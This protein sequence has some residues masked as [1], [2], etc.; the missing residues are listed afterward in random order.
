M[1]IITTPDK[2][3][4][5]T[6]G[7][8]HKCRRYHHWHHNLGWAR[9]GYQGPLVH[10][11]AFHAGLARWYESHSLDEAINDLRAAWPHSE[12]V[13][14]DQIP[15]DQ[16]PIEID[17]YAL[18]RC[19]ALFKGY[20]AYWNGGQGAAQDPLSAYAPSGQQPLLEHIIECPITT[21]A[22]R[23]LPGEPWSTSPW[24]YFGIVDMIAE[25][26]GQ[27]YIVDHKTCSEMGES[28]SRKWK[29][30]IQMLGYVV[31]AETMLGLDRPI[32]GAIINGAKMT[33]FVGG[34]KGMVFPPEKAANIE[35]RR[36]PIFYT[37]AEKAQWVRDRIEERRELEWHYETGVW[38]A[39]G[40]D[41][42][43]AY[44]GCQF[45]DVCGSS[46]GDWAT[47]LASDFK[48]GQHWNPLG[49]ERI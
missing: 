40:R 28:F 14:G 37:Q 29:P 48:P 8:Y 24:T 33:K 18:P 5:T 43:S 46:P 7:N 35:Y 11:K 45:R 15:G 27:L 31:L 30:D 26:D 16:I 2:I 39:A 10:G 20:V 17:H 19:E 34:A 12:G 42:C 25:L 9:E 3:D 41:A 36:V 6:L 44:G 23:Y 1:P 32:T 49:V 38:P 4:A 22:Q 47:R 21:L 13:P